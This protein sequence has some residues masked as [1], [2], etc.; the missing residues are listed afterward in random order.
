MD[1]RY[2]VFFILNPK[3]SV[4]EELVASGCLK[5]LDPFLGLSS[6]LPVAMVTSEVDTCLDWCPQ[7]TSHKALTTT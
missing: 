2:S 6:Q 1:I 4:S 5:F 7:L 3:E